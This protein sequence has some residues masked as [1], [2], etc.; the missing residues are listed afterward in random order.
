M[1]NV[2]WEQLKQAKLTL[3]A[4][5]GRVKLPRYMVVCWGDVFETIDDLTKD[6]RCK[7]ATR[8]IKARLT[9]GM[10][11]EEAASTFLYAAS[12]NPL[13][14]WGEFFPSARSLA[15]DPRCQV[16]YSSLVEKL[17]DGVPPEEAVKNQSMKREIKSIDEVLAKA[18]RR[19]RP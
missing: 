5:G 12:S 10:S 4:V 15:D 14:C 13:V 7:V 16:V 18:Q 8:T 1:P 11:L 6:P 3:E 17:R 19:K 2:T 9:G